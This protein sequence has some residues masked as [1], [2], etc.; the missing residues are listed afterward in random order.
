MEV[1]F[2]YVIWKARISCLLDEYNLKTYV[3]SVVVVLVDPDPLKKYKTEMEKA[4]RL[5]LD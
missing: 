5:I 2:N 1:A 3:N 4:K